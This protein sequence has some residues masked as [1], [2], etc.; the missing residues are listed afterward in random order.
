MFAVLVYKSLN[1]TDGN[2]YLISSNVP[3][4]LTTF[5]SKLET[6]LFAFYYSHP[7]QYRLSCIPHHEISHDS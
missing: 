5:N 6:Q 7:L 3:Q 4:T 1:Y 2:N